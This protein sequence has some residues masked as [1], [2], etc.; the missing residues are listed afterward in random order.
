MKHCMGVV[1]MGQT[2]DT[3]L[4]KTT[5]CCYL[6]R[7]LASGESIVLLGVRLS[8]CHSVYVC[9]RRISLSGEGNALYPVFSSY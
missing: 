3:A 1:Y 6:R 9:D 2:R 7:H 4:T 5:R 8:R